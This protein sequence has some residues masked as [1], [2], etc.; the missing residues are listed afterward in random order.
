MIKNNFAFA[1]AEVLIALLIIGFISAMTIPMLMMQTQNLEFKT[2]Y[3]K[4]YSSINLAWQQAVG[5]NATTPRAGGWCDNAANN[6][7]FNVLKTYLKKTKDCGIANSVTAGCWAGGGD[8]FNTAPNASVDS[9]IDSSG[10]SWAGGD[11][12]CGAIILDVN[13]L[14]TP[15]QFGR[16]RFAL[17][18]GE[19]TTQVNV[20]RLNPLADVIAID[21]DECP[22]GA[23][24]Y[25][26][27][28]TE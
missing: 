13:G 24:Y 12:L 20:D 23:C 3:K 5:D 17:M 7:N 11:T 1:L 21:A 15:N 26:S 6:A 14:K 25:S 19:S 10:I 22:R 18:M 2:S 27:W 16:D 4:A 8:N 28:L 9:F